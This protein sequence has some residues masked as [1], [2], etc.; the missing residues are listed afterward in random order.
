MSRKDNIIVYELVDTLYDL[1]V[2]N[3]IVCYEK[4]SNSLSR[5]K[6]KVVLICEQ[7]RIIVLNSLN[8]DT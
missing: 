4:Q 5:Y 1:R 6:A 2:H 8:F 3:I 7:I